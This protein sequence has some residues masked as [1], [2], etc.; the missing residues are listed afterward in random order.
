MKITKSHQLFG[1]TSAV[2][3][4]LSAW[5]AAISSRPLLFGLPTL[6]IVCFAVWLVGSDWHK[7]GFVSTLTHGLILGGSIVLAA[8]LLLLLAMRYTFGQWR[9]ESDTGEFSASFTSIYQA[10]IN[11][12]FLETVAV[13]LLGAAVGMLTVFLAGLFARLFGAVRASTYNPISLLLALIAVSLLGLIVFNSRNTGDS[14]EAR[15]AQFLEH[16]L[17]SERDAREPRGEINLSE[18]TYEEVEAL[19]ASLDKDA[20]LVSQY[21]VE[22]A[23]SADVSANAAEPEAARQ[24]VS[25][26]DNQLQGSSDANSQ[27]TETEELGETNTPT[28]YTVAKGDTYACIA[29][30]VYGNYRLWPEIA[31]RNQGQGFNERHLYVG[32]TLDLPALATPEQTTSI[33]N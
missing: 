14:S 30:R 28:T 15:V 1:A 23:L 17:T 24:N 10:M 31:A 5:F 25:V 9:V 22:A 21:D 11:G 32:A 8:R 20:L 13:V 18:L 19:T 16:K 33:C 4:A 12:S 2:V 6:L 7:K 27:Q 29:E 26:S 3:L